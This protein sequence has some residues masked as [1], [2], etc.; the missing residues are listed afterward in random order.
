MEIL[1]SDSPSWLAGGRPSS[2]LGHD[3][4]KYLDGGEIEIVG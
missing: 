4:L 2:A 1:A 3:V